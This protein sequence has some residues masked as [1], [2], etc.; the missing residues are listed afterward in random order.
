MVDIKRAKRLLK[1]IHQNLEEGIDKP[2]RI[3]E[4][5]EEVIKNLLDHYLGVSK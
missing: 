2:E 1:E 4:E 3:L 5:C